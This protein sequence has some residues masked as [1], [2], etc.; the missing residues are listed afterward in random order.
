MSRIRVE[1]EE[2]DW[3]LHYTQSGINKGKYWIYGGD[4]IVIDELDTSKETKMQ[5]QVGR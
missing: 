3:P 1:T 4:D 5:I 2:V